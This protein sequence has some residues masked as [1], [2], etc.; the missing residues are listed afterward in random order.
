MRLLV[1]Q[2]HRPG[3]AAEPPT[4]DVEAAV[5]V[6]TG[7]RV[8]AR[9]VAWTTRIVLQHRLAAT[10]RSGRVFLGG[11]RLHP[12]PGGC[13]GQEQRDPGREQPGWKLALASPGTAS[14]ALLDSYDASTARRRARCSRSP[15]SCSGWRPRTTPLSGGLGRRWRPLVVS[16]AIRMPGCGPSASASWVSSGFATL[17]AW[18]P[19][20]DPH[21]C[22]EAPRR[23][24][25]PDA[26]LLR[27]QVPCRLHQALAT[28]AFHLLL[29]AAPAW[30]QQW[31]QERF[32]SLWRSGARTGCGTASRVG[33]RA[34]GGIQ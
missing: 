27:G 18:P 9:N 15:I 2:A 1:V 32:E 12:Q 20:K 34:D 23:H 13:P 22:V 4:A 5:E 25:L 24:R 33:G 6:L 10:F 14:E 19:S 3:G 28:P 26:S 29:C 11:R 30:N 17:A 21:G 31:F 16:L 7:G 8:R